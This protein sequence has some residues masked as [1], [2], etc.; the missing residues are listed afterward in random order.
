M[1]LHATGIKKSGAARRD[2]ETGV[3]YTG[4]DEVNDLDAHPVPRFPLFYRE[5]VSRGRPGENLI[6]RLP[7]GE[8]ASPGQV[9]PACPLSRRPR[10][11]PVPRPPS[12]CTAGT[13]GVACERSN[14]KL[15][16]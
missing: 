14:I 9:R 7:R 10:F 15:I 13:I 3:L 1:I 12:G 5:G 16:L 4:T 2:L 8:L 11:G 6:R